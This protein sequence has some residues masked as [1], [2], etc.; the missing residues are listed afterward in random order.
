[1]FSKRTQS[2]PRKDAQHH[3]SQGNAVKPQEKLPH[4]LGR[5]HHV[6]NKEE[7]LRGGVGREPVQSLFSRSKNGAL[8]WVTVGRPR[9][10]L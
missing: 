9:L 1:M 5:V 2:R 3:W 4:G 7:D 8:D 10:L 6:M